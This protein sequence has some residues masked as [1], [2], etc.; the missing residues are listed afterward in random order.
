[1][2]L[3]DPRLITGVNLPYQAPTHNDGR[4]MITG[5][6][7]SYIEDDIGAAHAHQLAPNIEFMV[8]L[9]RQYFERVDVIRY[10]PAFQGW[11]GRPA[12]LA[13]GKRRLPDKMP[14]AG[15]WAVTPGRA[16]SD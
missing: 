3:A 11:Q 2:P 9:F 15:P 12:L 4:V 16:G 5:I 1:M 14:P 8:E 7:W 10:P 6:L 13:S